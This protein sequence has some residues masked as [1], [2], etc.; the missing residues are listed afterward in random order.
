MGRPRRRS[1]PGR[2]RE[3]FIA[4]LHPW[5]CQAARPLLGDHDRSR[6]RWPLLP[7]WCRRAPRTLHRVASSPCRY[8]ASCRPRR[9][10]RGTRADSGPH[11]ARGRTT[12]TGHWARCPPLSRGHGCL[13]ATLAI[14]S[15]PRGSAR[16]VIWLIAH[17]PANVLRRLLRPPQPHLQPP[18]ARVERRFVEVERVRSRPVRRASRPAGNGC[19]R[20][21]SERPG[22]A[23]PAFRHESAANPSSICPSPAIPLR[24][25]SSRWDCPLALR[26]GRETCASSTRRVACRT[27]TMPPP[28]STAAAARTIANA[29]PRARANA[30]APSQAMPPRTG[31]SGA[32]LSE[33]R[34][35]NASASEA[36]PPPAQ[37]PQARPR[38][39]PP[40]RTSTPANAASVNR[41]REHGRSFRRGGSQIMTSEECGYQGQRN[42]RN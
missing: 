32:H 39:P 40:G 26:H 22:A 9:D 30:I 21:Q 35:R 24:T 23:A 7:P 19:A 34:A 1:D 6:A 3:P 28:I 11:A 2:V 27:S 15:W 12:A 29:A 25:R 16:S 13:A 4:G 31:R 18:Q 41:G 20:V 33:V 5:H 38:R 10:R 42:A 14:R 36:A 8:P 37:S 17:Q